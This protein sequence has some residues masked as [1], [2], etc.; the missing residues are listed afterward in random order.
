MCSASWFVVRLWDGVSL[1]R[2]EGWCCR[3][4]HGQHHVDQFSL[5]FPILLL[6]YL[7][8]SSSSSKS[9]ILCASRPARGVFKKRQ[10]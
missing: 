3:R 7:Q 5:F 8:C 2:G 4:G 1:V 6:L 9:S 10:K